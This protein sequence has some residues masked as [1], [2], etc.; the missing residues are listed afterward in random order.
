MRAS[1]KTSKAG[2]ETPGILVTWESDKS[3]RTIRRLI[4]ELAL[5]TDAERL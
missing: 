3:H 1:R 4:Q 5:V 2:S